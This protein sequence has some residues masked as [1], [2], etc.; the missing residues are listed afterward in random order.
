MSTHVHYSGAMT[1]LTATD[2]ADTFDIAPDGTALITHA[3]I[4]YRAARIQ[5]AIIDG[6]P[7]V[8]V[9]FIRQ[10]REGR[11][12]RSG[13]GFWLTLE[14]LQASHPALAADLAA[15]WQAATVP[16]GPSPEAVYGK[17]PSS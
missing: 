5:Q 2:Q 12:Y 16:A 10:T 6:A 14:H 17:R 9:D 1:T 13:Q 11:D 3:D 7:T 8:I 15:E 4:P